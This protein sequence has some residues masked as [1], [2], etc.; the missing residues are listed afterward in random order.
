MVPPQANALPPVADVEFGGNCT[1]YGDLAQVGQE[2]EEF[3]ATV[4][5]A[6]GRRPLLYLTPTSAF[7]G[8][9]LPGVPVWIRNVFWEPSLSDRGW[10]IWQFSDNSRVPGIAGLVDRNALRP[11]LSLADLDRA[12]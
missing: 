11:G 4:E 12:P 3:L 10:L 5:A 1:S 2:L 6:W 7:F 8:E 9:Q